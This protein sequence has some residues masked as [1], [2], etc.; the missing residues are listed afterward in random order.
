[1]MQLYSPKSTQAELD[2]NGI[3]AL[4]VEYATVH[5]EVNGEFSLT[6]KIAQESA[7]ISEA[8]IGSIVK[9]HTPRGEQFFRL[10]KPTTALDGGKV[11]FAWHITYD[12]AQDIIL[13][14][15]WV[16]ETGADT[17]AG[18][19]QAGISERR[20][21]GTSDISTVNNMRVV[22]TSVLG[23]II[24]EQDNSFINRW[25][26]EIERNNFVVNV[27]SRLGADNGVNIR[28][29][30]NLTGLTIDEDDTELANRIIPTGLNASDAPVMLP[31]VYIDSAR[32]GDTPVPHVRHVHFSDIKIGAEDDDGNVIYPDE[33]AVFTELRNR[34]AQMYN[35][36]VD[37]PFKSATVEF[38]ELSQTEEYK[39]YQ[40]LTSVN[41]G[42]TVKC[43]YND[44]EISQRVISYDYDALGKKYINVTLGNLVPTLGDSLWAQ[45]LD[46][47]ALKNDVSGTVKQGE[48][49]NNV[50]IT[51]ENGVVTSA[52]IDGINI[53]V[54]QNAQEGFALYANGSYVG[55]LGVVNGKATLV[56]NVITNAEDSD[57]WATV[58]ELE[59]N[60]PGLLLFHNNYSSTAPVM[61]LITLA[62]VGL[63]GSV[64][65]TEGSRISFLGAEPESWMT[66]K[67]NLGVVLVSEE[68]DHAIGVDSTGPYY[69][70]NGVTTYF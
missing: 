36:G 53:E 60:Y 39:N 23:A 55:G 9:A 69:T 10:S 64:L 17:L 4:T 34:I 56:S 63:D 44:I 30:K 22:R 32:I 66:I 68:G 48:A 43:Y 52:T 54:R 35:Q 31:E 11:V 8:E 46:L 20:F 21:S 13:N 15:G 14:R 24:G 57:C 70:K 62:G 49:Y 1:M 51:H 27:K 67:S 19:L 42:D 29:R 28:Y 58:G 18:I 2:A 25:G 7:H 37:V 33:T 61:S 16:G 26:G 6:F 45:D 3:G 40:H 41:L 5:E 12:L 38:V 65:V 59:Q 50:T 47:S